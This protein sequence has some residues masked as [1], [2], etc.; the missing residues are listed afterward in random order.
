MATRSC[1]DLSTTTLDNEGIRH[2]K[3][4][5]LRRN[6]S[7]MK[8]NITKKIKEVTECMSNSRDVTDVESKAKEFLEAA[9]HFRGVN[10]AYHASLADEFEIQDSNDYFDSEARRIENFQ[11]TLDEWFARANKEVRKNVDS[12]IVKPHDSV[13]NAG[14][15]SRTRSNRSKSSYCGSRGGSSFS[16][17]TI[18]IAKK[19]SLAAE[20]AALRKQQTLQEEELRL[21]H[22]ALK[23][24]QQQEEAKLH[25]E[26]RKQQLQLEIQIAKLDA[27]EQVYAIAEQG[28]Q[29]V[30]LPSYA[31]TQDI[32]TSPPLGQPL[33][34]DL[35][36]KE[37]CPSP[38]TCDIFSP[39]S[40][41]SQ[42]SHDRPLNK[43]QTAKLS[44]EV[45]QANAVVTQPDGETYPVSPHATPWFPENLPKLGLS[46]RYP[47]PNEIKQ[48]RSPSP[49][50][51]AVGEK[52]I[53]DMID[54]QRQ[55]QRH[56]E[57][58]MHMQQ[59]RDQQL[60]GQHQHLSLTLTL[61]HAEVQTFD[62][63]PV[64]YCNF[65]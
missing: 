42:A 57:Q 12:E 32:T 4:L 65:I 8:G 55:Q 39:W 5:Q 38:P 33:L 26:Q 60:Q 10:S 14:T 13:S 9:T 49:S 44:K 51:S 61:P 17:K 59:Y 27:E 25:L 43:P 45:H 50:H 1:D 29:Y 3:T 52:F 47:D 35:Q 48:E 64:N 16:P 63:D 22:E 37:P 34:P 11:R 19:A 58:L 36:K 24:Q 23:Y 62:G 54:I 28:D 53:Q 20:A 6:R 18:A 46:E 30:E 56:N 40:E 21:K 15:R 31:R 7:A 2:E 41:P